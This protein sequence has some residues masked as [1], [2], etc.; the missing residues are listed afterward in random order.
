MVVGSGSASS[1]EV[2]VAGPEHVSVL[3]PLIETHALFEKAFTSC[4]EEA[5]RSA[6]AEPNAVLFA[7]LAIDDQGR[8]I[9]YAS[10]TRD[11]ATWSCK[12]FLHL[13]CLYI[14]ETARGA[15]VGSKLLEAVK[16]FAVRL[17]IDEL[18]WQTPDWN[19]PA[20]RF[21]LKQNA[22]VTTKR[23]FRLDV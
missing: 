1:V 14:V 20:E 3:L 23:R 16:L 15:G 21:Y 12:P 13:D 8:P 4:T 17:G 19:L 11:F 9:G 22:S 2:L 18:Q 5:L 6:L 7:W 10:A